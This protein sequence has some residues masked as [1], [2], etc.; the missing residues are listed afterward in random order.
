MIT[1]NTAAAIWNAYREI[2]A[3]EK[4]L[5]DMLEERSKP[6]HDD[7]KFAPTLRDAFGKKRHIQMGI[8]CG[9]D[10]HRIYDVNP[11]LAESVIRAHIAKKKLDLVEANERAR[12]EIDM[13]NEKSSYP[14]D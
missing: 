14:K 12:M 2:E 10:S 3:S 4:L 5:S 9:K 7:N 8:P 6:F 11:E 1:Q 13:P